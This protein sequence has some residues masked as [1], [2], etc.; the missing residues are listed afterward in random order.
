MVMVHGIG[1]R[2]SLGRPRQIWKNVEDLQK[3]NIKQ[4]KKKGEDRKRW[5]TID[6][7]AIGQLGS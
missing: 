3:L 6:D 4:W 1:R 7:Q 5:K 2:W